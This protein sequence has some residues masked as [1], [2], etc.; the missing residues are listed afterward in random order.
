[1]AGR[2]FSK[3]R[4]DFFEKLGISSGY[5]SSPSPKAT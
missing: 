1:M 2:L 5:I 3:R 4:S